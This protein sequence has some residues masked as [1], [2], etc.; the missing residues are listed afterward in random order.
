M[1]NI[2]STLGSPLYTI[3]HK[4][5]INM[6]VE[7]LIWI[8]SVLCTTNIPI[9][10]HKVI[11]YYNTN[12]C[13]KNIY[14]IWKLEIYWQLFYLLS[15]LQLLPA[16][17]HCQWNRY[18]AEQILEGPCFFCACKLSVHNVL[19]IF[20]LHRSSEHFRM[21]KQRLQCLVCAW[22]VTVT[23]VLSAVLIYV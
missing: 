15:A 17:W 11:Y 8:E 22:G 20:Y 3:I 16:S 1:L 9:W 6:A 10:T 19:I 12:I 21:S 13:F 2:C 14:Q 4:I 23:W 7:L 18:L 5:L